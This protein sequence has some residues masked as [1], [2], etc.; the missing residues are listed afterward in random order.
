MVPMAAACAALV[1]AVSMLGWLAARA[2]A[3]QMVDLADTWSRLAPGETVPQDQV[4]TFLHAM[5]TF[6]ASALVMSA[7]ISVI[8]LVLS[9]AVAGVVGRAVLGRQTTP[10]RAW[11]ELRPLLGPLVGMTLLIGLGYLGGLMLCI[12]PGIIFFV[13]WLVAAPALV[14]ERIGPIAAMRRSWH[15]VSGSWWRVFGIYLLTTLLVGVV[16]SVISTPLTVITASSSLDQIGTDTTATSLQ[17]LPTTGP[18]IFAMALA[19]AVTTLIA[20]PL[21]ASVM[22]LLYIDLRIRKE[23]L[24]PTLSAAA[25]AVDQ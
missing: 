22:S 13:F 11:R 9:G 6:L 7:A 21:L 20:I 23:N 3:Q 16:A 10:G 5:A 19:Q 24:A 2:A 12:V 1:F 4:S 25:R 17:F 14:L 8:H 18:A 15:L